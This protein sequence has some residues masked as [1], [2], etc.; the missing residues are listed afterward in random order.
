MDLI[1]VEVGDQADYNPGQ[2]ASKVDEFV[3]DKAHNAGCQNIV[4]HV[5]I[6][7][8]CSG[9]LLPWASR[10]NTYGPEAFE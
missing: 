10:G 2:T 4:L 9:Q 5:C 3:H 1:F 8:L 6:P 7:T